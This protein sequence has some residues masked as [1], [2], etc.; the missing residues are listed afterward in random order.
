MQE[1]LES[2]VKFIN[3]HVIVENVVGVA[4]IVVTLFKPSLDRSTVHAVF[5]KG[6]VHNK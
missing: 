2:N 5:T 1:Q 4:M 3:V 6:V